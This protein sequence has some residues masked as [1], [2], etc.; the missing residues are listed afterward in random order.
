MTPG[1][2]DTEIIVGAG[3]PE[4]LLPPRMGR[5]RA[6]IIA[7]PG[8][9]SVAAQ[10]ADVLGDGGL[11]ADVIRVPDRDEA[12]T[13]AVV[14][15][16]YH[17]LATL[18]LTRDD[19][20][21]GVGGGAVT[22]LAGFVAATWLRGVEVVHVPTTLLAAVDAS[23]GGKTG[24]NLG[25]KNLVGA[26]WHPSR[27]V[28]DVEILSQ[29]PETLKRE[30]LVEALKTGLVGD[31]K[32]FAIIE[33]R[34]LEVSLEDVVR[35]ALA[36]KVAVVSEDERESG[37]RAV[38]NLGHT[39]GHA[40]EFA[41]S[42]SHGHSVA[43][44]LIAAASVSQ[45]KLGFEELSRVTGS[46]SKLGIPTRADNLSRAKVMEL[47]AKDKKRGESGLRMVLLQT[48]GSPLVMPVTSEDVEFALTSVGV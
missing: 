35:R 17:S 3:M 26:F 13:I 22:D 36:V 42:L 46:V 30:G 37:R 28:I 8:S 5:T 9:A 6:A 44:G 41:S 21:V 43:L 47:M 2:S 11:L 48:I 14:E 39:V 34:G 32:L 31:P 24:I 38:L 18:G 27:V 4:P 1:P 15:S 20:V 23:V 40:I 16:V 29:I 33:E 45:R 10:V 12:K 19:T 25:G 7:Q